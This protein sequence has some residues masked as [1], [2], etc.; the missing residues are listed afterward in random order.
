MVDLDTV[1]RLHALAR[2]RAVRARRYRDTRL[3]PHAQVLSFLVMAGED[4]KVH[5]F[6]IGPTSGRPHTVY[7]IGDPRNPAEQRRLLLALGDALVPYVEECERNGRH[8]QI[9]VPAGAH[10]KHLEMEADRYRFF[11]DP[12]VRRLGEVLA[13][14]TERLPL[15][16]QQCLVVASEFLS[17]HY[18]M[19]VA[20]AEE[21]HLGVLLACIRPPAWMTL[22][23]AVE[24]AEA[25]PHGVNTDPEWD[26]TVLE[27]LVRSYNDARRAGSRSRAQRLRRD[28]RRALLPQLRR[29]HVAAQR[30]VR[31]MAGP[32]WE[33]LSAFDALDRFEA[34]ETYHFLRHMSAIR[35][36]FLFPLRDRPDAGARRLL[37]AEVAEENARSAVE[38]GDPLAR[39]GA[40]LRGVVVR[41]VIRKRRHNRAGRR[42]IWTFEIQTGQRAPKVRVDDDLR[43]IDDPRLVLRVCALRTSVRGSVI[44]VRVT[45]GMRTPGV[46]PEGT[47]IEVTETIPDWGRPAQLGKYIRMRLN[48]LATP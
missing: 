31:I 14:F 7:V 24:A 8:P 12:D 19:P 39:A 4:T 23:D 27:P 11:Q 46:P 22:L 32:R 6:A 45:S 15:A 13:Y 16:G 48:T 20:P 38:I 43:L 1:L 25:Q 37:Q 41:G 9:I 3:H 33:D 44:S 34:Y 18:A 36:S 5:G 29:I 35:Q 10:A 47:V 28:I 42:Q 26:G 21:A 40:R 17:R 30:A 2:G